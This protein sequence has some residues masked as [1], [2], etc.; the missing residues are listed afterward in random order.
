[1]KAFDF[2]KE[3][4]QFSIGEAIFSPKDTLAQVKERL[5]ASEISYTEF[6]NDYTSTV[7]LNFNEEISLKHWRFFLDTFCFNSKGELARLCMILANGESSKDM[8]SYD[9]RPVVNDMKMVSKFFI[10][11]YS[12][13]NTKRDKTMNFD[14]TDFCWGRFSVSASELTFL[15][16][17]F[18]DYE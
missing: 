15:C 3:N 6:F 10:K 18:I 7:D 11:L 8:T 5:Q 14:V 13:T 12:L 9:Y 4:G 1:M 2:N 16:H 17:V